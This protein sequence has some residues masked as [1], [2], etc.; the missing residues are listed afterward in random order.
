[1]RNGSLLVIHR[2]KRGEAYDAIPGGKLEPGETPEEAAV[3]EVAEETGMHI[4]V[5]APVLEL[6]NEDRREF[7]FDA[8]EAVG[9]P[10]LGGP[11]AERHSPENAYVLGWI[12]LQGLKD[13]P[14]KPMALKNWM[15]ARDWSDA[16]R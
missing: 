2:Q 3:R 5:G 1:V 10:V 14:L 12:G 4:R 11:E 7:Y 6:N 15:L 8:L 13:A 16:G 9:E